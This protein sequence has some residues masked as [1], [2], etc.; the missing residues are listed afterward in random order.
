VEQE[1]D[2]W[3]FDVDGGGENSDTKAL[4]NTSTD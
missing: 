4:M 3:M 2:D 1:V